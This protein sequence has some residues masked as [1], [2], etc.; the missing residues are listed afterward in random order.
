MPS[1]AWDTLIGTND[2]LGPNVATVNQPTQQHLQ[3]KPDEKLIVHGSGIAAAG[4]TAL[5]FEGTT[6]GMRKL[7][8][9]DFFVLSIAC[10]PQND[11]EPVTPL[12]TCGE[13]QWVALT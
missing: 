1:F 11:T 6:K 7:M 5:H 9:G 8:P 3:F 10:A 12:L 2:F 13:V 4:Q